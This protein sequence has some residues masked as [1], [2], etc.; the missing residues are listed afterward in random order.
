MNDYRRFLNPETV[1]KLNNI[2]LKARLVVEGFI[3]GLHRS[4]YHGFSVEFAE[5]RPYRFGDEIRKIDWKV[6][7]KTDKYYVKQYEEET[8]L[9]AIIAVDR[10]ASMAY[11]SN[12]IS[13]FEY[14]SYLAA[15][16]AYL[17]VNQ[18]DA[19]GLA[20]FDSELRTFLPPSSKRTYLNAILK[21][22][23]S[24]RPSNETKLSKALDSLAERV[25]RRG[26]AVVISDFLDDYESATKALQHFRHNKNE[27][28]AFQILDPREI[29][30]DFGKAAIFKDVETGETKTADSRQLRKAHEK[31]ARKFIER[32]KRYCRT[33]NI[34]YNL[35]LT[36]DPFD[37]AMKEF[38][39]KRKR[40]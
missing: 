37:K 22:L 28:L 21:T 14:A 38:I 13:K 10:S 26:L 30:F 24:A 6:F 11:S 9:R 25:K 40:M 5:Y 36:S 7:G 31:T 33:Q 1:A 18:R 2:E 20:L 29:D 3:A 27:V 12:G 15:A 19:V 39:A 16:L 23:D 35:I 4:P 32:L 17:L 34:D 8:N